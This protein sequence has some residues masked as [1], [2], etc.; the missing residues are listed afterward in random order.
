MVQFYATDQQNRLI[1]ARNA[2]R[3][4][5]YSCLECKGVVRVRGGLHKQDHFFHLELTPSCRQSSKSL[6]HLQT[7]KWIQD[8]FLEGE[9]VLEKRFDEINR[10]ADVFWEKK[11]LIFEVQCSPIHASEVRARNRDYSSIGYQVV[12]IL[13]EKRFNQW[14]VSGAELWLQKAPH[15]FTDIDKEKKGKI[16]DQYSVFE[17][18][19]RVA[20]GK[21][22]EIDVACPIFDT[23][24]DHPLLEERKKFWPLFF[25]GDV[26]CHSD[27][28]DHL[29]KK[30]R[31]KNEKKSW[32]LLIKKA[33][34]G[35]LSFCLEA[36]SKN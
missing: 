8:Q 28:L 19:L 9:C 29:E 33:Y 16:Y 11:K 34:H 22:T 24:F 32:K 36:F 2:V 27:Q 30:D 4:A 6:E 17:G 13:H 1:H 12:W 31:K 20:R 23:V 15:Y 18:G 21:K 35:F 3:Q 14:R 5:N 26:S 10:I 25:E 7:Q